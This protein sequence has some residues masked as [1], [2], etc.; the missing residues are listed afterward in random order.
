MP[1][2]QESSPCR[3]PQFPPGVRKKAPFSG[4]ALLVLARPAPFSWHPNLMGPHDVVPGRPFAASFRRWLL[5]RAPTLT[6]LFFSSA[7]FDWSIRIT[8]A[9]SYAV[10]RAAFFLFPPSISFFAR[11]PSFF[12]RP[13]VGSWSRSFFPSCEVS[14]RSFFFF[15]LSLFCLSPC[16]VSLRSFVYRK[17]CLFFTCFPRYFFQVLCRTPGP[18]LPQRF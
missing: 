3:L 10:M 6:V 1:G 12:R 11:F 17:R 5:Q 8:R 15:S 9:F 7:E 14:P 2:R 4:N 16:R 18:R 13:A